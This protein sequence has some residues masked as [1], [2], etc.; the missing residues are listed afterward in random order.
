MNY[1]YLEI[2]PICLSNDVVLKVIWVEL[3]TILGARLSW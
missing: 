3:C 1:E 2:N